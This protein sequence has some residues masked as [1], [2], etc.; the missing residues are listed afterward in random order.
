MT[1][2]QYLFGH[3][4]EELIGARGRC[5]ACGIAPCQFKWS[6]TL[7]AGEVDLLQWRVSLFLSHSEAPELALQLDQLPLGR[8][9]FAIPVSDN[10][11]VILP[12]CVHQVSRM[13]T[14]LGSILTAFS[15][16]R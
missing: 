5:R 13:E 11:V 6:G 16:D 15:Q 12:T 3:E 8:Q 10:A 2:S 9:V 7:G 4:I 1:W 14:S